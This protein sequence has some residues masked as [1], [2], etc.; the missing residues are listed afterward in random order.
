[1]TGTFENHSENDAQNTLG[2]DVEPGVEGVASV[3][4]EE[5]DTMVVESDEKFIQVELPIFMHRSGKPE[6]I[7]SAVVTRYKDRVELASKIDTESGIDFFSIVTSGQ[8]EGLTLGGV[9]NAKLTNL[10]KK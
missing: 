8:V 10:L 1:M 3:E 4:L 6:V 9:L 7:G 2:E 5:N